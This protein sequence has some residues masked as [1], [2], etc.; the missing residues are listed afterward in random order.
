MR[1]PIKNLGDSGEQR[2]DVIGTR[3]RLAIQVRPGTAVRS[4][5][6]AKIIASGSP[7]ARE[8]RVNKKVFKSSGKVAG[9]LNTKA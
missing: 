2:W 5:S 7:M 9:L 3:M 6:Q 8:P 1:D 4:S